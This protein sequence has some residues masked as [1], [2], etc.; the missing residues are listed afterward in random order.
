[1]PEG[2]PF[3]YKFLPR[4]G[5]SLSVT[6]GKPINE[7]EIKEALKS[8]LPLKEHE[9]LSPLSG[10][11]I[12]DEQQSGSDTASGWLGNTLTGSNEDLEGAHQASQ[13]ARIRS[14]VT[15]LL[16]KE[17]ESLGRQVLNL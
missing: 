10:K 9:S 4:R 7:A 13:I 11:R 3:P 12:A 1:M 16:H 15:A 14:T 2:R 8:K 17:V 6:F 5:V